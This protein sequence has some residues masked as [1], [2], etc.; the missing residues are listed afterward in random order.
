M[1]FDLFHA[2]RPKTLTIALA[3]ILLGQVL[4]WQDLSLL[5]QSLNSIIA[6]LCFCCCIFL[7][8]AVNLANDYFD[9]LSGVDQTGRLGPD[10][11]MQIG[12][13]SL[14]RLKY[15]IFFFTLCA[16][17]SGLYLIYVGGWIFLLFGILSLLGIYFY[18]GSQYSFA[19]HS[20]GEITVFLFFGWLAVIG[21]YYLQVKTFH[22][23]LFFPASEIGALVAAVMLVNNIRDMSSDKLAGKVTLAYRLGP[24]FSRGL[25]C[26][27][28]LL[29]FVSLPFNPYLPWLNSVLL[30]LHLALCFLIRKRSAKQLNTQLV[31]TSLL[32]LLWATAYL[33]SSLLSPTIL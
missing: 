31:Q 26:T 15:L 21:S 14:N 10:R 9:H 30:P 27:L 13:I 22:W 24:I 25:Y 19:A 3:V 5:S 18:S 16:A 7:Q 11:V 33:F 32:V 20:L 12:K 17:S 6:L 2:I 29:P 28:L 1:L 23:G 4:A 8:I